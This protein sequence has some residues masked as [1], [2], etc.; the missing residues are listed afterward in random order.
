[1]QYNE[2]LRTTSRKFSRRDDNLINEGIWWLPVPNKDPP[3]SQLP[4]PPCEICIITS[5]FLWFKKTCRAKKDVLLCFLIRKRKEST[6]LLFFNHPEKC[7]S[8]SK[9]LKKTNFF[10]SSDTFFLEKYICIRYQMHHISSDQL[11]YRIAKSFFFS[12]TFW[13]YIIIS[14]YLL[15]IQN[16]PFTNRKCQIYCFDLLSTKYKAKIHVLREI[17]LTI[18]D[19]LCLS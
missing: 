10:F 5:I 6:C 13:K 8:K 11:D 9:L 15:P 1:M 16:C 18:L 19:I 14:K 7:Q 2:S 4:L 12:L 3:P 17:L